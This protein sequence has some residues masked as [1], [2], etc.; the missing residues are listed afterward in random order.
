MTQTEVVFC[1]RELLL[2]S[3]EVSGGAL[4]ELQKAYL[5]GPVLGPQ[6]Q[7]GKVKWSGF[8]TKP[9]ALNQEH[10]T[11]LSIWII[12]SAGHV[13]VILGNPWVSHPKPG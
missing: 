12:L 2:D 4:C 6:E 13:L 5:N 10:R 7:A 9:V 8:L 3:Q 11:T 1:L